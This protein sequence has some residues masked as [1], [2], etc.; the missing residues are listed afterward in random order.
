MRKFRT[1]VTGAAMSLV[2][3]AALALALAG[4]GK[5]VK[6]EGATPAS[7]PPELLGQGAVEAER[8]AESLGRQVDLLKRDLEAERQAR[9]K[10]EQAAVAAGGAAAEAK[11]RVKELQSQMKA[12]DEALDNVLG[13]RK[14]GA[15]DA[16]NSQDSGS[17]WGNSGSTAE[18]GQA[19]AAM[20][21]RVKAMSLDPTLTSTMQNVKDSLRSMELKDP[22]NTDRQKDLLGLKAADPAQERAAAAAAAL[23]G[24][25]SLPLAVRTSDESPP[26]T[27]R[28]LPTLGEAVEALRE[29]GGPE[30][31]LTRTGCLIEASFPVSE[32]GKISTWRA[33]FAL[34]E[35]QGTGRVAVVESV[36]SPDV[37]GDPR[38]EKGTTALGK[39]Q[40]YTNDYARRHP[41]GRR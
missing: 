28:S 1:S 11:S 35:A 24:L 37:F 19:G 16:A 32:S 22:K 38:A 5:S 9:K 23:D 21:D 26:H 6:R 13:I 29:A 17:G 10:A 3:A 7:Q 33:R 27:D 2:L 41:A 15:A 20:A 34:A 8:K 18:G 14:K 25:T 12:K 39:V 30:F 36:E 31:S 40:R 4:C